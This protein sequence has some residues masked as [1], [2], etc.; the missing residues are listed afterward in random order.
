MK[1]QRLFS[2]DILLKNSNRMTKYKLFRIKSIN[3]NELK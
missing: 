3:T 2:L 1:N